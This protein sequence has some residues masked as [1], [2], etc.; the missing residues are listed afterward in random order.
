MCS[1]CLSACVFATR[2][3]SM[4][5]L[6]LGVLAGLAAAESGRIL[7]EGHALGSDSVVHSSID[8]SGALGAAW[9]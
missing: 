3:L 8:G 9:L 7:I 6:L 2:C 4:R 5:L 1:R